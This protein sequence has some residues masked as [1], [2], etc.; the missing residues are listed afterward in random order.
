MSHTLLCPNQ[1]RAYGVAVDDTPTQ[2]NKASTHSLYIPDSELC[3]PLELDGIIF[4]FTTRALMPAEPD[5]T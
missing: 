4:G 2:Y 5:T 1:L 3:I